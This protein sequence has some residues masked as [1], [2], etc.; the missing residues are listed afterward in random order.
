[1]TII[2]DGQRVSV[3]GPK[4]ELDH[5]VA[6]GISIVQKSGE[7]CL[8]CPDKSKRNKALWG[9]WR[10]LLQNAVLGVS[11]GFKKE[12]EI[13]GI[14]YD[15]SVQGNV[16]ELNLGFPHSIKMDIPGDVSVAVHKNIIMVEGID[17]Q[18][19]G[20]FAAQI[21]AQRPADPYKGK[22]VRYK[23]EKVRQ[24]ESKKAVTAKV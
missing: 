8:S 1:M 19:V 4:G 12:L 10:A 16:L 18:Q 17:K 5:K 6:S 2:I 9:L 15:A 23:G 21:R 14:G 13:R 24:K 20:Q 22:G 7:L 3:K 11:Q